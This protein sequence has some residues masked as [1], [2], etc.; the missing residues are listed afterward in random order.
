MLDEREVSTLGIIAHSKDSS[1]FEQAKKAKMDEVKMKLPSEI[2][3][4]KHLQASHLVPHA[5]IK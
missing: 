5:I 1:Y 4:P 3:Q 2:M